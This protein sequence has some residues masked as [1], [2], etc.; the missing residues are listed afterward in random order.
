MAPLR[1]DTPANESGEWR[2]VLEDPTGDAARFVPEATFQS[3]WRQ[4]T[5]VEG[6]AG[7]VASVSFVARMDSGA[8]H[9][10]LERVRCEARRYPPPL[11]LPYVT[12]IYCYR[13]AD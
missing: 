5:D 6:V 10:L 7:R 8:R 4:P 13:R 3:P 2:R 9:R 1:G 12:E 11:S